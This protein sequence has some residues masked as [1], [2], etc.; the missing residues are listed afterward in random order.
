VMG[1]W[2]EIAVMAQQYVSAARA[3]G[4]APDAQVLRMMETAG[5]LSGNSGAPADRF[6]MTGWDDVP[7]SMRPAY[8]NVRVSQWENQLSKEWE[9]VVGV[10]S[11]YEGRD[12]GVMTNAFRNMA[13]YFGVRVGGD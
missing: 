8:D 12:P 2:S 13:R 9:R 11:N 7:G 1:K 10:G 3:L 5:R 4:R 6:T